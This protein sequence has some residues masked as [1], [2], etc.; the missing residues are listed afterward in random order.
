MS[1]AQAWRDI[2]DSMRARIAGKP[3]PTPADSAGRVHRL[4]LVE[5]NREGQEVF[6]IDLDQIVDL[7]L[8]VQD[9]TEE[10]VASWNGRRYL[11][12]APVAPW[13]LTLTADFDQIT[14]A[15]RA[16]HRAPGEPT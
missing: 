11:W 7:Q 4:R 2:R 16:R 12:N 8:Q 15:D 6:S 13:R 9:T 3:H 5:V 14:Y 1:A 10:E